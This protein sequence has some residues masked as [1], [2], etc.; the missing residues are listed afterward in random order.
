MSAYG[1]RSIGC[2]TQEVRARWN[3]AARQ[4]T[5]LMLVVETHTTRETPVARIALRMWSVP[6][7]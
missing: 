4:G 5:G 2:S 1:R 6:A 7:E 3:G